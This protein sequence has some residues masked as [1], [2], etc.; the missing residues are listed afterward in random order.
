MLTGMQ[1]LT[2]VEVMSCNQKS[3]KF[4]VSAQVPP[5]EPVAAAVSLLSGQSIFTM[6]AESNNSS[7]AGQSFHHTDERTWA[8]QFT[9]LNV[10]YS[11]AGEV[12]EVR[13]PTRILLRDLP[14]LKNDG[15]RNGKRVI[16]EEHQKEMADITGLDEADSKQWDE[17]PSSMLKAMKDVDWA[18]IN[19]YMYLDGDD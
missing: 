2:D 11:P 6:K 7:Q 16:G 15:V 14:D 19:N 12:D 1:Y 8:A 5:P 13:L 9:P 4:S 3:S 10:K 18:T 17:D